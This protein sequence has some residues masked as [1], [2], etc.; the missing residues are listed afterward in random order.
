MAELRTLARPYAKAAFMSAMQS[1]ALAD[2]AN[3]LSQLSAAFGEDT[4]Q[5]LVSSPS[6]T[7]EAK[8]EKLNSVFDGE[9]S[10]ALGRFISVLA[11]NKRL[12]LLP[13][14]SELFEELK[15]EQE[16]SVNVVISSAF[17]TD[18]AAEAKIAAALKTSLN[19]DV[20]V[21]TE[22]DESLIGGAL[23]KAGDV[24]IDDTIKGR[25]AKLA[26]AMN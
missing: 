7:A 20:Q 12:E 25:L 6:L 3:G 1:S 26:E 14:I 4:V 8:A 17:P 13:E 16:S 9:V 19:R 22:V 10:D 18:S 23:I 11:E 21:Q 5:K 24:V 2:W 15:A